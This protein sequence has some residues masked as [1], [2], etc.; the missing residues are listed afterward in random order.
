MYYAMKFIT[1]DFN[2]VIVRPVRVSSF[3]KLSQARKALE[4]SGKQGYVKKLGEQ[5][6]VW[7]N[8]S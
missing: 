8:L 1:D 5:V 7:S 3:S 6:P 2:N 4:K